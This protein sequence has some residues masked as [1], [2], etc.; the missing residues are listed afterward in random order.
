MFWVCKYEWA[1][2]KALSVLCVGVQNINGK[3]RLVH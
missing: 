1:N 3:C 2:L